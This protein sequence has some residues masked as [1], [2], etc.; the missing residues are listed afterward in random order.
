MTEL[1][2]SAAFAQTGIKDDNFAVSY[3]HLFL[4]VIFFQYRHKI[5]S[6]EDNIVWQEERKT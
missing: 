6:L 1:G 2:L 5:I 3:G 4:F